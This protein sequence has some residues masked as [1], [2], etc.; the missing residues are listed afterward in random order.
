MEEM[1][2]RLMLFNSTNNSCVYCIINWC[3]FGLS[4]QAFNWKTNWLLQVI[5]T[6]RFCGVRVEKPVSKQSFLIRL[7]YFMI[8]YI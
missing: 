6:R 5:P 4:L 8:N 1:P 7:I 3:I 2:S